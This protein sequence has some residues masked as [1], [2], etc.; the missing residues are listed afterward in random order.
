MVA[1]WNRADHYIFILWFLLLCIFFISWPNLSRR[2][3]NVCHTSTHGVALVRIWN[4]GLKRAARG[5]LK[6]RTQKSRHKSPSGHHRTNLSCYIFA[7]KAR[8]NSRKK[9]VKQQYVLHMSPQYG[10]LR[11]TN[12]WDRFGSL[13]HPSWFQ[14]VSRIAFCSVTARQSSSEHQPNF[15]ALDRGRHLYSTGRPSRWALV[16]ISSWCRQTVPAVCLHHPP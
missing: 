5:S 14:R 7:T 16:H 3:L 15:A 6:Y 10:E 2:R 9:I 8:I 4:A 13:G 12:G 1:L 11:P